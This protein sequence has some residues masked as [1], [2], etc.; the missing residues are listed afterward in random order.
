MLEVRKKFQLLKM[1]IFSEKCFSGRQR[2]FTIFWRHIF[3]SS[4]CWKLKLVK[5]IRNGF[6]CCAPVPL[7]SFN[8]YI[9]LRI[10]NLKK[11]YA[12]QTL[13]RIFDNRKFIK[14]RAQNKFTWYGLK[15]FPNEKISCFAT[16]EEIKTFGFKRKF[17]LLKIF[18]FSGKFFSG[19]D[20][21]LQG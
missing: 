7:S 12:L 13:K 1:F 16:W 21:F 5:M 11:T 8:R 6:K 10:F 4:K 17:Q 20:E 2:I 14:F 15:T 9:L 18:I 19:C 3:Q